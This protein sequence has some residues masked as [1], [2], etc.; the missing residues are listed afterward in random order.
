MSAVFRGER[1]D[2]EADCDALIDGRRGV[3]EQTENLNEINRNY[4]GRRT[5]EQYTQ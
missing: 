3:T 1:E 4:C 5:H 2:S